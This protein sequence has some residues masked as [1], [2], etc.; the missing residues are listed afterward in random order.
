ML[1][2]AKF[3]FW[4]GKIR[5]NIFSGS[6]TLSPVSLVGLFSYNRKQFLDTRET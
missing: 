1:N 2:Q 4:H 5:T 3:L 6:P